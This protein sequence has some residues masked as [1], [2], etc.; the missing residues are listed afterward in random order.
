[1]YGCHVVVTCNDFPCDGNMPDDGNSAQV[2]SR[3]IL[4]MMMLGLL[5][6]GAA[7]DRVVLPPQVLAH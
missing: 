6:C 4:N 2:L 5:L 7:L 1:M 3:V